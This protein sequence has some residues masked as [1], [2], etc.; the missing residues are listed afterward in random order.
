VR[1]EGDRKEGDRVYTLD[2][3]QVKSSTK[4]GGQ[5]HYACFPNIEL[6]SLGAD[7]Y[8]TDPQDPIETY[9]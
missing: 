2:S 8:L 3:S 1:K 5:V 6:T 4:I 7:A 9:L